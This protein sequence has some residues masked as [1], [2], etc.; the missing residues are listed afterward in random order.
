MSRNLPGDFNLD[1][2]WDTRDVDL[3]ADGIVGGE[4]NTTLDLTGD[5][6]VDDVDLARWLAIAVAENGFTATNDP[7]S[8]PVFEIDTESDVRN[9]SC[10]RLAVTNM[11]SAHRKLRFRRTSA[12]AELHTK[13]CRWQP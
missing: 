6:V 10:L 8:T 4:N 9:Q 7:M 5:G 11:T 12:G 3:L 2:V 1:G 13:S